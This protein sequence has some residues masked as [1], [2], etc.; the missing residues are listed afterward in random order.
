M[1]K[2]ALAF[3]LQ[4][5]SAGVPQLLFHSFTDSPDL[6]WRLLGG[7]VDAEESPEQALFRELEE[8]TGLTHL[9]IVRKLGIQL[10]YKPYIQDNVERHDFLLRP[11]TPLP[12]S[13]S[14]TITGSGGDAGDIFDFHWL[15]ADAK[16]AI[17]P[18]HGRYL[19]PE[20][21]PE[22]FS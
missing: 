7:G 11:Q 21:I 13:W 1:Q 9:T 19:T 10:Y 3:I 15:T 22:F 8:E 14:H 20:Y 16:Q 12:N 5:S 17:D 2:K 4:P 18:E 6:P